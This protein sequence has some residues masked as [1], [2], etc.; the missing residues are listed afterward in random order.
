MTRISRT[1]RIVLFWAAA[2]LIAALE[3]VL[4]AAWLVGGTS[5]RV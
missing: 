3:A 4:T 1:R 2:A 5:P